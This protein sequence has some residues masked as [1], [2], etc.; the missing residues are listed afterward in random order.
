MPLS[1][2]V[3][4]LQGNNNPTMKSMCLSWIAAW[5]FINDNG[6][7]WMTHVLV[8]VLF[9]GRIKFARHIF[10]YIIY[11]YY[12]LPCIRKYMRLLNFMDLFRLY[13]RDA[14]MTCTPSKFVKKKAFLIQLML[15]IPSFNWIEKSFILT[16]LSSWASYQIR[17]ITGCPC[18][19]NAGEVFLATDF[20][21][22]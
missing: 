4:F 11:M 16:N 1:N 17:D 15:G 22:S 21:A 14:G 13:R 7:M 19:G 3:L 18:V 2:G 6:R 9:W 8:F 20:I 5:Y 10:V 12:K